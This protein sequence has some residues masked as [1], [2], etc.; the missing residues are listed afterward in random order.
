[1]TGLSWQDILQGLNAGRDQALTDFGVT[2]QWVFDIVRNLPDTQEKVLDIA[3]AA[4]ELGVV[5]LGLGG[6]EAGF[7]PEMFVDTF[8]RAKKEHLHRVP[9]A[10]EIAGPQS[11][12][13]AI[14]SLHA[15]RIGHGVRSIE[16]PSLVDYLGSNSI[17]LEICPSSNVC[18]NVYPDFAAHPLRKLWDAGLLLTIGS[19]DPPMF[20]TDL[21]NEYQVLINE[22]SFTQSDLERISLN[23]I[24]ASF[25]NQGEK[26]KLEQEFQN[27]FTR[28]SK[29]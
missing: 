8:K 5:A 25:L 12:W 9:H 21:N 27:E 15:E 6:V 26:H 3:L 23:A 17:P 13:S 1:L 19:D 28:L 11:V 18:L 14:K 29:G 16:D 22:F 20:S 7:P 4:R 24:Q 2:W 10:G